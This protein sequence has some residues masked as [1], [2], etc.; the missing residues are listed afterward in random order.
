M[1]EKV[2]GPASAGGRGVRSAVDVG[3][4]ERL[5]DQ[6]WEGETAVRPYSRGPKRSRSQAA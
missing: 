5:V 3:A 4:R 6:V 1:A 2:K